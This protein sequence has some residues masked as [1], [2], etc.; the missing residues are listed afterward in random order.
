MDFFFDENYAFAFGFGI[1]NMG[2]NL[3]YIG[4]Y[5]ILFKGDTIYVIPGQTIKHNLQY[6]DIP[7]GIKLKTEELG[8]ATF[9][10]EVGFNPMI[11]LNA[12]ASLKRRCI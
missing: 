12:S 9:F 5:S 7:L 6:L 8:Y 10:L 2:G 3:L 11:N 1:N 4:L